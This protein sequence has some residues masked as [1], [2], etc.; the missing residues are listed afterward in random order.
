MCIQHHILLFIISLTDPSLTTTTTTSTIAIVWC[1]ESWQLGGENVSNINNDLFW[2]KCNNNLYQS[3]SQRPYAVGPNVINISI[4]FYSLYCIGITGGSFVFHN[5]L[6]FIQSPDQ[7]SALFIWRVYVTL[8]LPVHSD[9]WELIDQSFVN[10]GSEDFVRR[11]MTVNFYMN[12]TWLRC[13]NVTSLK[14]LVSSKH[15]Y[16]HRYCFAFIVTPSLTFHRSPIVP[17]GIPN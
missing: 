6:L 10:I 9:M 12:M 11:E 15:K 14:S 8:D 3:C 16:I 4:T 7:G 1:T 2:V 5:I 13:L 17:M